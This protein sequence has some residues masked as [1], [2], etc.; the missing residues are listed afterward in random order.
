MKKTKK[1]KESSKDKIK[2][3]KNKKNIS[4]NKEDELNNLK[5]YKYIKKKFKKIYNKKRNKRIIEFN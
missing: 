1:E 2:K 4:P 3:E 5:I